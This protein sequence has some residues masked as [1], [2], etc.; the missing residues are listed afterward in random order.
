MKSLKLTMYFLIHVSLYSSMWSPCSSWASVWMDRHYFALWF[1]PLWRIPA[2][3]VVA[4]WPLAVH[5]QSWLNGG[6]ITHVSSHLF[7]QCWCQVSPT[8]LDTRDIY[9]Y[10]CSWTLTLLVFF[11]HLR[12]NHLWIRPKSKSTV[13]SNKTTLTSCEEK[14][15]PTWSISVTKLQ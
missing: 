2:N 13:A 8:A 11:L 4:T 3:A 12:T 7:P 5:S 10:V 9:Y 1:A 15:I 14:S 6:A